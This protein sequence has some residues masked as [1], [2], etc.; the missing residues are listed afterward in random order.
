[1]CVRFTI[2][3]LDCAGI[4]IDVTVANHSETFSPIMTERKDGLIRLIRANSVDHTKRSF[5]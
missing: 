5:P 4:I 1:M 2:T 3:H